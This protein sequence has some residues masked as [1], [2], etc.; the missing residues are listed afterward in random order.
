[1]ETAERI[2]AAASAA[3]SRRAKR[4]AQQAHKTHP[5]IQAKQNQMYLITTLS[6]AQVDNSLINR[7]LPKEVLLK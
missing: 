4:L 3:S 6:P 2:S 5:V 1:M 7:V